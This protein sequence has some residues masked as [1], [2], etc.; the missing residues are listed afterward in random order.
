MM[1]TGL[2]RQQCNFIVSL[3]VV[4]YYMACCYEDE[5]LDCLPDLIMPLATSNP[6]IPNATDVHG[7]PGCFHLAT[8][9]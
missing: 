6:N 4:G 1:A 8:M 5:P 9:H 2:F 3:V 7:A